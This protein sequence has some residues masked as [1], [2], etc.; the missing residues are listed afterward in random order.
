MASIL[1]E[2]SVTFGANTINF[3]P[4]L[5]T[6][7]DAPDPTFTPSFH[8][9]QRCSLKK[10]FDFKKCRQLCR[11]EMKKLQ[12]KKRTELVQKRRPTLSDFDDDSTIVSDSTEELNQWFPITL[13]TMIEVP[14]K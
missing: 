14:F 4:S 12:K 13:G 1:E 6:F 9:P 2:R 5:R 7:E 8:A 10:S 11:D 3:I